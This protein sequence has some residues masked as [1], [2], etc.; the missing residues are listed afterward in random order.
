MNKKKVVQ[1]YLSGTV[2]IQG[3]PPPLYLLRWEEKVQAVEVSQKLLA[4]RWIHHLLVSV[5]KHDN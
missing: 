1:P 2:K 5:K 3:F 4:L